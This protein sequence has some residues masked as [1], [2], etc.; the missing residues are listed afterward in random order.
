MYASV[1]IPDTVDPVMTGASLDLSLAELRLNFSEVCYPIGQRSSGRGLMIDGIPL[2]LFIQQ[3]VDPLTHDSTL[4][5]LGYTDQSGHKSHINFTDAVLT[6][7]SVSKF[8][9][10][11]SNQ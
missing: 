10:L 4:I 2:T 11:L 5:A 1:F 3:V 6:F 9:V 8:I 7:S